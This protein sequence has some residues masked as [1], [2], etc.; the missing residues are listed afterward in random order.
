[1]AMARSRTTNPRQKG[2]WKRFA[3][4]SWQQ[5]TFYAAIIVIGAM[6]GVRA[7]TLP[8]VTV[9]NR[10]NPVLADRLGNGHQAALKLFMIEG[11]Q[12][13]EA[14]R[15]PRAIKL[16]RARLSENP[17]D[18]PAM[19]IMAFH[20]SMTGEK[21]KAASLAALAE[22]ITRRDK[23]AQLLLAQSAAEKGDGA[24]AMQHFDMALRTTERGREQIFALLA[25]NG[26]N[27]DVFAALLPLVDDKSAWMAD[28][29]LYSAR[30]LP[31]GPQNAAKLLLAGNR[32]TKKEILQS[33]GTD[34]LTLL[35]IRGDYDLMLRLYSRMNAGAKSIADD[36]KITKQTIAA[37]AG[38]LGWTAV[39]DVSVGGALGADKSGK[40]I[41]SAYATRNAGGVALRRFLALPSGTYRLSERRRS[42]VE[43][44]GAKAYWTIKCPSLSGAPVIWTSFRNDVE[45]RVAD[46]AGPT[47][48]ANCPVQELELNLVGG[49]GMSGMEIVIETFDLAR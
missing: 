42:L 14:L 7:A 24:A 34:L 47:I 44:E 20:Y 35:S 23:L 6:V 15:D 39:N 29:L 37:S 49:S 8:M 18:A 9:A 2:P 11:A 16:G 45:Y 10:S 1:M 21:Q 31:A 12:D 26:D 28:Y 46:A 25:K 33:V 3:A 13:P 4:L 40:L 41:A 17:L 32:D 36:P 48:S 30:T 27:P 38:P 43:S 19:R 22:K 5:R